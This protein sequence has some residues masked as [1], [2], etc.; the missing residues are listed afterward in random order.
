MGYLEAIPMVQAVVGYND[1]IMND[2]SPM[3]WAL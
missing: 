3:V 2:I 1:G